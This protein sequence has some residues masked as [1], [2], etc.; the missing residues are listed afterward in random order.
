MEGAQESV[1][2]LLVGFDILMANG[3][4]NHIQLLRHSGLGKADTQ[5]RGKVLTVPRGYAEHWG[6]EEAELTTPH[7]GDPNTHLYTRTPRQ[8]QVV[9]GMD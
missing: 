9:I 7:V 2:G 5:L 3:D 4:L 6:L 8:L 1:K